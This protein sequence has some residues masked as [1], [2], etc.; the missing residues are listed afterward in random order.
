[1]TPVVSSDDVRVRGEHRIRQAAEKAPV[2]RLI[3]AQAARTPE[4]IALTC[5]DRHWTYR[6]LHARAGRLACRL[7]GL[8]VGP[9]VRVGLCAERSAELVVGLLAILE[10]GGAYVPLDPAFPHQRLA[11]M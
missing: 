6:E 11:L 7:R 9:D 10:A 3:A 1:M 2:H 5:G 4:A 8:G